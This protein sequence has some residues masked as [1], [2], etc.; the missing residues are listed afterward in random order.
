MDKISLIL[1]LTRPACSKSISSPYVAIVA[2]QKINRRP[3]GGGHRSVSTPLNTPLYAIGTTNGTRWERG[4]CSS[5]FFCRNLQRNLKCSELFVSHGV[6]L[7]IGAGGC[8]C[9]SAA[10]VSGVSNAGLS[11]LQIRRIADLKSPSSS[12]LATI[13]AKN[14]SGSY[15]LTLDLRFD[16]DSS[17]AFIE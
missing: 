16:V 14:L 8:L 7:S 3:E 6:L 15:L 17:S 10:R 4:Y 1:L 5:D 13:D 12:L 2:C 11:S 9:L